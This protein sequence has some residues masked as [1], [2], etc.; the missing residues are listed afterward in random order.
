MAFPEDNLQQTAVYWAPTAEDRYGRPGF[1]SPVEIRCRWEDVNEEFV[2]AQGTNAISFAHVFVDRDLRNG[3][4]LWLGSLA[5]SDSTPSNNAGYQL[6][7]R[8]DKLPSLDGSVFLRK[9]YL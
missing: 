8:F 9:A 7:R 1:S 6:I 5:S 2:T 4:A 3:G